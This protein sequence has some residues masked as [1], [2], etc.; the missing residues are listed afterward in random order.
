MDERHRVG[1]RDT[2]QVAPDNVEIVRRSLECFNRGDREGLRKLT[3]P[4]AEIIPLRAAL[5]GTVFS[6]ERGYSDFWAAM[7]ESWET[8]HIDADE[9]AERGENVLVVGSLRGR[10]RGT[11]VEVNSP[12]AFVLTVAD[13]KVS[14]LRTYTDIAEARRSAGLSG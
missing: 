3:A 2:S 12:I 10:A 6:G 5:E 9:F 11:E 1:P 4:D 13:E 14:R 8:I 7:D